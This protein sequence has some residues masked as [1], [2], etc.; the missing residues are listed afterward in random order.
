MGE[1]IKKTSDD[2]KKRKF[3]KKKGKKENAKR[4]AELV[5]ALTLNPPVIS[6]ED[7]TS[8]SDSETSYPSLAVMR[9]QEQ[10]QQTPLSRREAWANEFAG[11][12]SDQKVIDTLNRTHMASKIKKLKQQKECHT[13]RGKF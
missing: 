3:K 10:Q 6:S 9:V 8:S 11:L 1:P 12:I 13:P 2:K 5:Q 7:E 4:V